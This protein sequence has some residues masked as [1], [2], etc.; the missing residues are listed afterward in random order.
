MS[1]KKRP[2]RRRPLL[3]APKPPSILPYLIVTVVALLIGG[4][5][6]FTGRETT[7][8]GLMTWVVGWWMPRPPGGPQLPPA[9]VIGVLVLLLC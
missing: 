7:G 6:V 9:A 5:L 2:R 1:G 3:V 4:G 8:V